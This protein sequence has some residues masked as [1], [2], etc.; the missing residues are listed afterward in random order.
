MDLSAE[1]SKPEYQTGTYAERLALLRSKATPTVGHIDTGNLKLLE[2]LI[3][4]GLWRD[5]MA[6]M[7]ASA[8]AVLSDP[9]ST[10]AQQQ[11][12]Q[13]QLQVVAGFHEAIAEAKM[14]NKAPRP[15]GHS[16]N[17]AD[18]DVQTTFA[19]AQHPSIKLITPAEANRVIELA[20]WQKPSFPDATLYD[21]VSFFDSDAV[22]V[23]DWQEVTQ[24]HTHKLMLTLSN[25]LPEAS[26]VAVEMCESHDG[27]TWTSWKRVKSFIVKEP[28]VYFQDIPFN[29]LQRK[30]R[31]RG[32]FYKAVGTVEAV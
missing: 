27:Q 11:V 16:I 6:D 25:E 13:M 26:P 2:A 31:W 4:K 24:L 7:K 8:R 1:L 17:L 22:D 32:G 30:I 23:G 21:V 5:K 9:A 3:A 18:V 19:A 29:G 28:G 10:A 12:A 14:A 20:T 15:D